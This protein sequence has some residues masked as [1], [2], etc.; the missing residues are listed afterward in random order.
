[1][2][3]KGTLISFEGID[4]SGKTTIIKSII[5]FFAKQNMKAIAVREPGGTK[6][7]EMIRALLLDSKNMELMPK[8][9]ALLYSAARIQL[10]QEIIKPALDS[11]ITILADRYLDSTIAYQGYGRGINLDFLNSLNAFCSDGTLPKCTILLDIEPSVALMRRKEQASDRLENEGLEFQKR[12]RAG[13]LK[14]AEQNPD[15]IVI[16]D[17]DNEAGIVEKEVIEILMKIL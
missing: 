16:V 3:K 7:S 6:I 9:E 15:R 14:L 17:A 1:M 13:Y 11:G 10:V 4:G 2:K 8:T 5:D 12:V